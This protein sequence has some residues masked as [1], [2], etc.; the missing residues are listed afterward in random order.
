MSDV[1]GV[2]RYCTCR[3]D[4]GRLLGKRCPE[5]VR[6]GKHGKWAF[7]ADG[8]RVNGKRKEVNRLPDAARRAGRTVRLSLPAGTRGQV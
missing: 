1:P 4:D 3:G 8:A 6:N 5:Y 2:Y 7:K